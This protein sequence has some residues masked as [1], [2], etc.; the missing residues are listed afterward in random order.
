MEKINLKEN[1]SIIIN[2]AIL[3]NEILSEILFLQ[4]GKERIDDTGICDNYGVKDQI[5]S[6]QKLNNFLA[7][8]ATT[9]NNTEG[10]LK[11]IESIYQSMVYFQK[12]RIPGT[13][14]IELY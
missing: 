13:R 3:N 2:G 1:S 4:T 6:F 14:E 9:F 8:E 10:V 7:S 11:Q 5:E 12:F